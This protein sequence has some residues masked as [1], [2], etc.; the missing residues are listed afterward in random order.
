MTGRCS[1]RRGWGAVRR[2]EYSSLATS[3]I[4]CDMW[5]SW[6]EHSRNVWGMNTNR[7]KGAGKSAQRAIVFPR[8]LYDRPYHEYILVAA[9]MVH[10]VLMEP[11]EPATPDCPPTGTVYHDPSECTTWKDMTT[12]SKVTTCPGHNPFLLMRRVANSSRA[13]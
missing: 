5:S 3:I 8:V 2:P 13:F 9:F 4:C 7:S 12:G 6:R 11:G 1:L 10:N